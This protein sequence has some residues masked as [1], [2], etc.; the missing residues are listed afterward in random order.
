MLR[1]VILKVMKSN[2]IRTRIRAY[3]HAYNHTNIFCMSMRKKK[4]V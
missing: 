3:T 1:A 2:V 4:K